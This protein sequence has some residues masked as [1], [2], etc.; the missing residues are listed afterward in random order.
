MK[1][2]LKL[3]SLM[4]IVL[5]SM[6]AFAGASIFRPVNATYV[7]GIIESDTVWALIDSPFIV[8][9]D[10]AVASTA[11]LT[12]EPGVVVKF[13]GNF[14][15][16]VAGSLQAV[17]TENQKIT[18]T[19]NNN[20]SKAGDWLTISFT[21]AAHS[22][23]TN[24]VLEYAMNGL[25]LENS[26]V[27]VKNSE[28]RFCYETGI[29]LSNSIMLIQDSEIHNNYGS[30]IYLADGNQ[31]TIVNNTIKANEDGLLLS[32]TTTQTVNITQ[33][34][35]QSNTMSGITLNLTDYSGVTI[36]TN[37]I[38]ANNNG[39][40]VT[41]LAST[42]ITNNSISYNR[43]GF[44]YEQ[45]SHTAAWN[46]IYGNEIAMDL[47][48]GPPIYVNAEYNYWG[49]A[50]GPFHARL[51]P[52][53]KGN[54]IGGNGENI[55]FIFFL[56]AP[57]SSI[58]QRPT[59]R[60]LSDKIRVAPSQKATF[61]GT[62]SSDDKRIDMFFFDFGDGT[63]SSWTTLSIFEHAYSATGS[64]QA[65]LKVMDD[66]GVISNNTAAL[67][68]T[69]QAL[70][71]LELSVTLERADTYSEG[72]ISVTVTVKTGTTPV[73]SADITVFAI[74]G[75]SFSPSSGTTDSAGSWSTTFTAPNVTS[76]GYVR[77]TARASKNG[78][79]DGA[80]F[81]YI[82]VL[83]RLILEV[84][85]DVDT[86]KSEGKASALA[87][88]S[89]DSAPVSDAQVSIAATNGTFDQETGFS[90][91]N[92]DIVFNFTAP[93][94][95]AIQLNVTIT[96]TAVKTGYFEGQDQASLI[97]NPKLL[98]VQITSPAMMESKTDS[99]ITVLVT[100]D[101]TPVG[102]A[103]VTITSDGGGTFLTNTGITDANGS[104]IFIFTA[105]E[106]TADSA[107]TITA[108]A[109]KTG[110]DSVEK[111]ATITVASV[112]APVEGLGGL[113]WLTVILIL[114]PIIAVAV[115][116]ILIKMKI[117]VISR[118]NAEDEG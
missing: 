59:A 39:F 1:K 16:I 64:F 118:A 112:T 61:F 7:E 21:G 25:N 42:R 111:Q 89:C 99:Q 3:L 65:N 100:D 9:K 79:T 82:Q 44:F 83:A 2:Q 19:S 37:T 36:H 109:T 91:I 85:M 30:G 108:L 92:G 95:T 14:S 4:A 77:I 5:V 58:N 98:T 86:V 73:G 104:S 103:N 15:I 13:G 74:V 84:T 26:D 38:S 27:E 116:A 8:S 81:A 88:V 115:I 23:L 54:P 78:Y 49:D 114:I 51:N 80:N 50:T 17:G 46:D 28:I 102:G 34:N 68:I 53:G 63:N 32:G 101:A 6:F 97:V 55:D 31:A 56:S 12:I 107:V 29:T 60:L 94:T 35:V 93:K 87:H 113:P 22:T 20:E 40:Y 33:N 43:K 90:D 45:G 106:T 48:Y 110:Y 105:P 96:A 11:T 75:G 117:I 66:Y 41:S 10:V 72:Q 67:S 24:C 69:V 71:S 62:T 76:S 70:T 18:F 52:S 47:M 57:V